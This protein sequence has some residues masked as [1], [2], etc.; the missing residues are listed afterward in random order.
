MN[1]SSV[2]LNLC[3]NEKSVVDSKPS[4]ITSINVQV[5]TDVISAND[6]HMKFISVQQHNVLIDL[7]C[8]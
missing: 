3:R 2:V 6:N 7:I 1:D 8:K 5:N 4:A